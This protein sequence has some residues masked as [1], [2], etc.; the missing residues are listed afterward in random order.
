MSCSHRACPNGFI[1]MLH[2]HSGL[3]ARWGGGTLQCKGACVGGIRF[4]VRCGYQSFFD[5][6]T[7]TAKRAYKSPRLGRQTLSYLCISLMDAQTRGWT[8]EQDAD[9]PD[10]SVRNHVDQRIGHEDLG[11]R[12]R[13]VP[14][15]SLMAHYPTDVLGFAPVPHGDPV[16]SS[17]DVHDVATTGDHMYAMK[18]FMVSTLTIYETAPTSQAP[19]WIDP[20]VT[21]A[22][23]AQD[24]IIT[25]T[26]G[27]QEP[28]SERF[29]QVVGSEAQT[30]AS[31][32]RRRTIL[33]PVPARTCT[34]CSKTFTRVNN[35]KDHVLRHENQRR[36][37]CPSG[38][39]AARFN[40]NGDLALHAKR[41]HGI[42]IRDGDS[43]SA[44]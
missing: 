35:C 23:P 7:F 19:N 25:S 28:Q 18:E 29:R 16:S 44:L 2:D 41:M 24:S 43:S 39:C 5:C 11:G 12:F 42:I 8:F 3:L 40:T 33:E 32:R 4:Y 26:P 14:L 22:F 21:I 1:R 20:S 31:L 37:V 36:F 13:G 34:T 17:S 10:D 6:P 30:E 9:H 38:G 15:D 27:H